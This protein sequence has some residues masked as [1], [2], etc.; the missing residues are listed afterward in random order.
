MKSTHSVVIALAIAA[1]LCMDLRT[2]SAN[3]DLQEAK[4]AV[5]DLDYERALNHLERALL[6]GR[7]SPEQVSEILL[8]SGQVQAALGDADKAEQFFFEM[9]TLDP[10]IALPTGSSPKLMEP[11]AKARERIST[12]QGLIAECELDAS[13]PAVVV[14]VTSDPGSLVDGAR[15]IYRLPDSK[16]TAGGLQTVEVRSRDAI[17]LALP[18]VDR[19]Q[20]YCAL[21]D[22]YGNQLL[23]MGSPTDL[24]TL[25]LPRRAR[26]GAGP[27][28]PWIKHWATWGGL[29]VASAAAGGFFASRV[30]AA[31]DELDALNENSAEH[32]FSAAKAIEDRGR[33]NALLAN[34]SLGVA[35]ACAVVAVIQFIRRPKRSSANERSALIAPTLVPGGA[36]VALVTNF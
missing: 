35:G 23:E 20:L 33:R 11:F 22:K 28:Q 25:K 26:D 9:L 7:S 19:L 14:T 12:S 18:A 2:A 4:L 3:P 15:A 31:Q 5:A 32:E 21:I 24:Q 17:T 13:V 29:T 30:G 10:S 16:D 1:S 27:S 34:L 36:G 8:L 6:W